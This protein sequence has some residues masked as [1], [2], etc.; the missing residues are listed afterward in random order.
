MRVRKASLVPVLLQGKNQLGNAT[1]AARKVGG[2]V[3]HGEEASCQVHEERLR[4]AHSSH[5]LV[6]METKEWQ[7]VWFS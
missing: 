6:S 5:L 7:G 3:G 2:V 1:Y 4:H